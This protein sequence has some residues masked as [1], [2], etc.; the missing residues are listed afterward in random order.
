MREYSL[1]GLDGKFDSRSNYECATAAGS[2][3]RFKHTSEYRTMLRRAIEQSGT[4]ERHAK[5]NLAKA[6]VRLRRWEAETE[7]ALLEAGG[8]PTAFEGVIAL[9]S[10]G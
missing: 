10:R 3:R 9:R 7:L 6:R 4:D 1:I 2:L 8:T 5:T